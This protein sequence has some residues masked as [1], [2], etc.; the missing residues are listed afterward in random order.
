MRKNNLIVKYDPDKNTVKL[1]DP[2]GTM[3]KLSL[4][5]AQEIINDILSLVSNAWADCAVKTF[6]A[7][8]NREIRTWRRVSLIEALLVLM[9][10]IFRILGAL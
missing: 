6:Q 2:N 1:R 10:C 7:R 4:K 3:E 5:E 8:E 9:M